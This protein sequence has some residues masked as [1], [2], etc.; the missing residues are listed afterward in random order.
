MEIIKSVARV[1]DGDYGDL[2]LAA[3]AKLND[4]VLHLAAVR[5]KLEAVD[6]LWQA[7]NKLPTN[8][9]KSLAL[10]LGTQAAAATR[11]ADK[12]Q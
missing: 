11:R 6:A 7:L 8:V 4:V 12:G 2:P 3:H 1:R 10:Q 9:A 5:E